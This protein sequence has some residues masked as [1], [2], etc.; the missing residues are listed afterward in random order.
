MATYTRLTLEQAKAIGVAFQLRVSDVVAVPAG[1]VNSNY[2]LVLGD[3]TA[4]FA[5]VYEE[6]DRTG[7]EGEARLLD[8]LA[9]NGVSTPRPLPRT[10]GH[11]FTAAL[12]TDRGPR[13][14]ALFPWRDGQ[15]RCQAGVTAEAAEKVGQK[16]AEMHRAGSTF[17]EVRP[18]RFRI[19][20]MRTRLERIAEAA[21]ADLRA[22][23]PRLGERLDRAERARNPDL[24]HGIIHGDLFR[25]NV[26]WQDE[27][28]VAFLDFESACDGSWAYDL[29][30]TVLAWCYGSDLD[31]KLTRAMFRGYAS[32]RRPGAPELAALSTE[33]RIGALRFTITRITDFEMRRGLGDRVMKDYKRF[34]ARHE[35]LVELGDAIAR[36]FE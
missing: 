28:P 5:R 23:A 18:G 19:A 8:H 20:D 34:F 2:R 6:Q 16:L 9:K 35:R 14:I 17:P 12:E 30:V 15:I 7:A 1:S 13:A 27:S 21:D 31:E 4:L 3:G 33:G 29:M 11:G 36:W 26:L 10:D 25:D 32:V 22:M 24:P